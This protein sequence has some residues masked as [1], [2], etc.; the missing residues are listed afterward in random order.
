MHIVDDALP[1]CPAGRVRLSRRGGHE[2]P[3]I[4]S[5]TYVMMGSAAVNY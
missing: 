4:S 5:Q 2:L 1:Y 3:E